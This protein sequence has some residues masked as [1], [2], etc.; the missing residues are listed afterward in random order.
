MSKAHF[1]LTKC[2]SG[3]RTRVFFVIVALLVS[4][5]ACSPGPTQQPTDAQFQQAIGARLVPHISLLTD[6]EKYTEQESLIYRVVNQGP[7]DVY[8][9]NYS[10]DLQAFKYDATK[11][12]WVRLKLGFVVD[13]QLTTL[14]PKSSDPVSGVYVIA[15]GG[16]PAMGNI[17]LAVV[18]WDDPA[19][20]NGSKI[21]AFK[22]IQIDQ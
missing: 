8:F 3:S 7:G 6:K 4:V 2:W 10:Y 12:E 17:R 16:I 20:P 1:S 5:G 9:A 22:D 19:N 11:K 21:A 13:A 15:P 18:G 14:A